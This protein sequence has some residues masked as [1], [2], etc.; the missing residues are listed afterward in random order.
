MIGASNPTSA[1]ASAGDSVAVSGG[2][3]VKPTMVENALSP[4]LVTVVTAAW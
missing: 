1:A 2:C 3:G 4:K